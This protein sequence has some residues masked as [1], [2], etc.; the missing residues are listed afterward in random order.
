MS[1]TIIGTGDPGVVRF[2]PRNNP[3][4]LR[5]WAERGLIHCEDA[6]DNSYETL[7]VREFLLRLQGINDM[8]GNSKATLAAE[9]F[10]HV[11]E[12]DRQQR[13]VEEAAVL[14]RRAQIQGLPPR[15]SGRLRHESFAANVSAGSGKYAF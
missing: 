5:Y 15:F 4:C 13:F 1:F 12:L 8:I 14:V 9:K 6:R 2:G 7:T 10:A 11:D 3:K